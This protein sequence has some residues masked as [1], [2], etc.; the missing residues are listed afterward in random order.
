MLLLLILPAEASLQLPVGAIRH[1]G[2]QDRFGNTGREL[3]IPRRG[4]AGTAGLHPFAEAAGA[5]S[6]GRFNL[7]GLLGLTVD[8]D[9]CA[10]LLDQQP[11]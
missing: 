8:E 10:S 7:E 2:Q 3:E 6:S 11:A 1:I 4:A 5:V 9:S